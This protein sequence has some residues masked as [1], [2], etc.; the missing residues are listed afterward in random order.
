MGELKGKIGLFPDNFVEVISVSA[1]HQDHEQRQMT[2]KFVARASQQ[3]KKNKKAH[4]R[5][6]LDVRNV[7]PG[8]KIIYIEFEIQLKPEPSFG[9]LNCFFRSRNSEETHINDFAFGV[10]NISGRK[11]KYWR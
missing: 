10:I 4:I 7:H 3:T 6:S 5:K 11:W 2:A 9:L 8:T 1:D